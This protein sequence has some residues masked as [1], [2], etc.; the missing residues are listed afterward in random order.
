MRNKTSWK[1]FSL[2]ALM[3]ILAA[4]V[5]LADSD[6]WTQAS[7]KSGRLIATQ[8][9]EVKIPG[10]DEKQQA[11]TSIDPVTGIS[12]KRAGT[13]SNS[14]RT[15]TAKLTADGLNDTLTFR[16]IDSAGK[17][18]V[19]PSPD[20]GYD[21]VTLPDGN[22]LVEYAASIYK[23]NPQK[24]TLS[25]FLNSQTGNIRKTQR[26][27]ISGGSAKMVVWG[28]RASISPDGT[29]LLYWTTRNIVATGNEDG[30]NW[31]KDLRTGAERKVYGAGYTVLGWDQKNRFYLDLGDLGIVQVDSSGKASAQLVSEYSVSA[32]SANHLMYQTAD[33]SVNIRNLSTG[34]KK[35]I[36]GSG[37]N[38]LRSISSSENGA[39]FA[40]LNA[41]NRSS[42]V[43]TLIV[44]D[45][46]TSEIHKFDEPAGSS[47]I[48]MSWQD[49]ETLLVQVRN[50]ESAHESTYVVDMSKEVK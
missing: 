7:K 24:R 37:L 11:V 17:M 23:L 2:T 50:R 40:L 44:V 38:H 42:R 22:V 3:L 19:L 47:I 9:V 1:V 35:V 45:A 34:Q 15:F 28:Q 21:I 39:W 36:R 29:Q 25:L 4:S 18:T 32:L 10:R 48:G 30:E 13:I 33:G 16:Y 5:A 49:S 31:I 20:L 27:P 41:P 14:T 6:L 26:G 46:N 8:G 43:S 12:A